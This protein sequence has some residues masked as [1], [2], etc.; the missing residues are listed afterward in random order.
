MTDSIFQNAMARTCRDVVLT[1]ISAS[2]MAEHVTVKGG[3]VMQQV[4]GRQK[5]CYA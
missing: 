3:V 2:S 5:A 4:L 1:L